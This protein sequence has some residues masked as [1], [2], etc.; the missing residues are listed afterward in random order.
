MLPS[1]A[2]AH[3]LRLALTISPQEHQKECQTEDSSEATQF[4]CPKCCRLFFGR[5]GK[6]YLKDHYNIEH[7]G[8]PLPACEEC[9]T[10]FTSTVCYSLHR[11]SSKNCSKKTA[12]QLKLDDPYEKLLDPMKLAFVCSHC[13]VLVAGESAESRFERHRNECGDDDDGVGGPA[14]PG[15]ELLVASDPPPPAPTPAPPVA[16]ACLE[17]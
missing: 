5:D 13:Q 14:V 8:K 9:D 17:G 7:L 11:K 4:A 6:S 16:A 12:E 3:I 10:R 1:S 15:D 2:S